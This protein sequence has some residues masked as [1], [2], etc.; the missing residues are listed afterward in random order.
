LSEAPL[1]PPF[2]LRCIEHALLLVGDMDAALAFYQD[3]LGAR[4]EARFPRYAMAELVAGASHLDLVDVSRDEGAWA[5]PPVA[6]GRNLDHIALRVRGEASAARRHLADRRVE[7]VEERLNED[8]SGA[9][10]SLYVRDPSGN[11]IELMG[12]LGV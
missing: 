7:I 1:A 4:L 2:E 12:L 5:R 3:V 10:L 8:A 9:E 6:G 11:T